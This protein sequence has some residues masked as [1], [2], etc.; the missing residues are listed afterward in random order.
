M[1]TFFD[2]GGG[3]LDGVS[4]RFWSNNRI[5]QLTFYS[6]KVEQLG[7]NVVADKIHSIISKTDQL[8]IEQIEKILISNKYPSAYSSALKEETKRL[9]K[10]VA[11]VIMQIKTKDPNVW[12]SHTRYFDQSFR[13][14]VIGKCP[15][16]LQLCI[17]LGGGGSDSGYYQNNIKWTYDKHQLHN[18]SVPRF[19]LARVPEP[20]DLEFNNIPKKYYHRFAIAYGLSIPI[21]EGPEIKL[22]SQVEDFEPLPVN[23]DDNVVDYMDTKDAYD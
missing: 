13:R 19:D 1:L 3:T 6:G 11:H 23:R 15:N 10:Q 17:F 12:T 7:V 21:G 22:P 14:Y 16:D 5:P 4:F 2:V 20:D 9:R 18:C 8:S